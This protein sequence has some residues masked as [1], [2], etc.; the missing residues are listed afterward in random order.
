MVAYHYTA[1]FGN[2]FWGVPSREVFPKLSAVTAYGAMGVQLFF[3][4]SGFVILMSAHGRPVGQFAASRISRLF[5]AYWTA[6]LLTA[7]L[8]LAVTHGDMNNQVD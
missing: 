6:V 2:L 7:F 3:I 4:I 8:L 1:V 5:P